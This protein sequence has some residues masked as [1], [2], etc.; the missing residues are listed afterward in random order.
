MRLGA[1]RR[2]HFAHW[3]LVGLCNPQELG[4][5][6]G[7]GVGSDIS[8]T[9]QPHLRLRGRLMSPNDAHY[10]VRYDK[11]CGTYPDGPGSDRLNIGYT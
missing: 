6:V 4:P 9:S 2:C 10:C 3:P 5:G 7:T 11:D 8:V 1:Q